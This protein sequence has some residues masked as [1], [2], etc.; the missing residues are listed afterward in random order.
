MDL[1]SLLD[2]L[3]AEGKAFDA[4]QADR[5][6]RRRNLSPDAAELLALVLRIG[7]CRDIVEI[8]T[9]NGYSTIW[10]ADAARTTGGSVTTVDVDEVPAALENVTRAGLA[11]NVV[12][13]TAD[14]A[15]FLASRAP[16]SVDL[17]FLDAERPEY[18]AWWPDVRRVLRP[19]GVLAIDNVLS[20]PDEVAPFLALVNADRTFTGSSVAVGKGLF[21][22]VSER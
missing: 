1:R 2:H 8:G 9:S 4:A 11:D 14:G 20:H 22:A 16:S 19:G 6:S 17:L 21:L 13:E 18:P 5:R 12:F 15:D 10:L 3:Y 7:G